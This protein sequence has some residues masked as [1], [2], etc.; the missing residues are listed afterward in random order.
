MRRA[1]IT[2]YLFL[3]PMVVGLL[4]FRVI[5]IGVSFF[6]S[7]THWNVIA[8]P[9][10]AGLANY[11]EMLGSAD[12]WRVLGN[13]G[14]F[15]AM[16]VP[17]V[18]AIGLALAVLVNRQLR[19][20][21]FFRGLF[22]L[23]YI[24]SIVAVALAWRWVFSTRFGLL[25]NALIE[26]F[27]ITNPP[28]WLSDPAWALPSV[29][30][31]YIWQSAGFVMLLFLAGLQSIDRT[32]HDAARLDGATAWQSFRYVTL[33]L[34]SPVVFFVMIISL[35][36]SSQTFEVTYALTEGGPNGASTTLAYS[37]FQN[38]F[39][40]YRMGYASALAYTLFALVGTMTLLNFTLRKRWVHYG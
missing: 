35:I 33:P 19:G 37:V 27:G 1:P 31:V 40:F 18:M 20:I 22:F 32:L 30:I 16:Y 2:P 5:P 8:P 38:A 34:L 39:V 15:A 24:T 28:A 9:Q 7:F 25:N 10:W 17:G 12:F 11:R 3:A 26:V 14:L 21:T 36:T 6:A 29:A 23:P 4:V 13:T